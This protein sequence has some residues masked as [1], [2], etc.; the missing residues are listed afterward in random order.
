ML[1][2]WA[3]IYSCAILF[4]DNGDG[5]MCV[6]GED[7]DIGTNYKKYIRKEVILITRY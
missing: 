7:N 3:R 6:K 1:G 4:Q 2:T 5:L